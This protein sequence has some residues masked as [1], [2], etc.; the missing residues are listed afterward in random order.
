MTVEM[1]VAVCSRNVAPGDAVSN[2]ILGELRCFSGMGIE[3]RL[4]AHESMVPGL[5]LSAGSER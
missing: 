5:S 3:T 1:K 4:F 2:D